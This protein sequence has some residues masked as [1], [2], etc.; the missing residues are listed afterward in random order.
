MS[1][2]ED[3]VARMKKKKQVLPFDASLAR[4]HLQYQRGDIWTCGVC[5]LISEAKTIVALPYFS[6]REGEFTPRAVHHRPVRRSRHEI[7]QHQH[8]DQN[9][10]QNQNLNQNQIQLQQEADDDVHVVASQTVPEMW[11]GVNVNVI[12]FIAETLKV[13]AANWTSRPNARDME[14]HLTRHGFLTVLPDDDVGKKKMTQSRKDL[15]IAV[16]DLAVKKVTTIKGLKQLTLRGAEAKKYSLDS[17][18]LSFAIHKCA[19]FGDLRELE[20]PTFAKLPMWCQ[21]QKRSSPITKR[22]APYIKDLVPNW[23]GK[24]FERVKENRGRIGL[25]LD[26]GTVRDHRYLTVVATTRFVNTTAALHTY[27][28]LPLV[29]MKSASLASS[30]MVQSRSGCLRSCKKSNRKGL[31]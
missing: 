2:H 14:A 10:N 8:Q 4:L 1:D 11:N 19:T 13:T 3:E 29:Q 24:F 25:L 23:R 15:E 22:W 21:R 16:W 20:V 9:Q 27:S 28:S 7:N 5:A 31:L 26:I 6:E 30:G 18:R 17:A 12:K